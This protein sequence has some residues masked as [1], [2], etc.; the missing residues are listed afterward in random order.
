LLFASIAL[1]VF[2]S[3]CA[4]SGDRGGRAPSSR[5]LVAGSIGADGG[6]LR[7]DDGDQ[8]GLQ[9]VVPAG[10]LATST[11]VRV[12]LALEPRWRIDWPPVRRGWHRTHSAEA[13]TPAL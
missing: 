4:H 9:L 6:T 8:A 12:R 10:A 13:A 2:A 11:E 3:G 1:S 7:V 5:V